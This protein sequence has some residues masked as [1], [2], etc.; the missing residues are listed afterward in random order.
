MDPEES[1]MFSEAVEGSGSILRGLGREI[2]T[3]SDEEFQQAMKTLPQLMATRLTFM[4]P[5]HH[6]DSRLCSSRNAA[7]E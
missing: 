1:F 3:V 2:H 6:G 7:T 5:E 4:S